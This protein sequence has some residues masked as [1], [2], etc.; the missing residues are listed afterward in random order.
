MLSRTTPWCVVSR[1]GFSW[2]QKAG[3]RTLQGFSGEVGGSLRDK[4]PQ[5]GAFMECKHAFVQE[6]V[7]IFAQICG[8]DNPLHTDVAVAKESMFGGTIVHGIL[9][10]SLFSTLF[11][12]SLH[13]AVY[14]NQT[15]SFRR[16]VH[17]GTNVKATIKILN[18]TKSRSGHLLTCSTV[19]ELESGKIAVEGEAQCLLPYTEYP[20]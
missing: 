14:V 3:R 11:G 7:N 8:D 12:R 1:L 19:V 15:L 13:G 17:V 18:K 4:G 2:S 20:R 10:S 5:I 9:V 6:D 16:P